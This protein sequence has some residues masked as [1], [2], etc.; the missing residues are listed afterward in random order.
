MIR[1]ISEKLQNIRNEINNTYA[2]QMFERIKW[3]WY[4]TDCFTTKRMH[5]RVSIIVYEKWRRR[6]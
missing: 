6:W 5:V 1:H 3:S 4:Q 2:L